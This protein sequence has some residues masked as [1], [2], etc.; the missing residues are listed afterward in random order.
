MQRITKQTDWLGIIVFAGAMTAFVMAISFGGS[1]YEWNSASEIVLWVLS[2]LL[3]IAFALT[4]FYHPFVS[5]AHKLYPT[6]FLRMPVMVMLQVLMVC[7]AVGLFVSWLLIG[8]FRAIEKGKLTPYIQVPVYYIPLY[9]QFSQV[10]LTLKFSLSDS[11]AGL[12]RTGRFC[13]E[14]C[15]PSDA[16]HHYDRGF[17]LG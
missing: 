13:F 17:L 14:S 8:L 1:V 12:P 6:H 5:V 3:T 9:F 10:E 15:S 16:I 4:Q 11:V 7:A 2:G